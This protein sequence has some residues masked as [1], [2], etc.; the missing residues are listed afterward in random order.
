MIGLASLTRQAQRHR[1]TH[2]VAADHLT[3]VV[4]HTDLTTLKMLTTQGTDDMEPRASSLTHSFP[5]WAVSLLVP[6]EDSTR[7]AECA[8]KRI[9]TRE[10]FLCL[11]YQAGPR[12]THSKG[13]EP[14]P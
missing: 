14:H 12:D 5:G 3:V 2:G 7:W 1:E 8:A 6:Q 13:L 11:E 10:I 9:G 4:L